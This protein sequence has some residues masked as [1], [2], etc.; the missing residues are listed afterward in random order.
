VKHSG[1]FYF[2]NSK[3]FLQ[4]NAEKGTPSVTRYSCPL[5]VIQIWKNVWSIS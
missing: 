2:T 1:A 5:T 4:S 3:V